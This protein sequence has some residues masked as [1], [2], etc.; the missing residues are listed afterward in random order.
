[1][2]KYHLI[3]I[4]GAGMSSLACFLADYGHIVQG[5]DVLE[6]F[7]TQKNLEL[8]EIKILPFSK[9]NLNKEFI[10]I[11]GN[12]FIENEEHL[13]AK[14][15]GC[16]TYSYYEFLGLLSQKFYSIAIAG[17][18]GKTTTTN[19]IRQLLS[20]PKEVN[21]LIGDGLG[22]GNNQS[23]LFVFEACEYKR[24]FLHY[25][26]N[27]AVLTNIDF[28]H[29]DY[30]RDILDVEDAFKEFIKQS[31]IIVY[32]GDDKL[33]SETIPPEK[34]RISFGLNKNNDYY[35]ENISNDNNNTSYDL[36]KNN[37]FLGKI[38]IPL[39][40]IH[41]VYNSL[42]AIS[43]SF[44]F[45]EDLNIIREKLLQ[46]NKSK[47][48]FEEHIIDN[49]IIISDYAHHPNEIKA[50]IEATT[51]KYPF[52]KIIIYFQPH[53]YTRTISFLKDFAMALSLSDKV[54]LREIFSSAREIDK[55]ISIYD[56]AKLI[57]KCEVINDNS[58]IEIFKKHPNCVIIFMG[59]GDIDKYCNLY[60]DNLKKNDYFS[61]SS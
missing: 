58:Y 29:P 3:G 43:I 54:Y 61:V 14:K 24:H 6:P 2:L 46:Y 20:Y 12:A 31:E 40:G 19:I 49:Q 41:S 7:F 55:T 16:E 34:Q 37:R 4:K 28:D 48:R 50:T 27:I 42:A 25:Y 53:T 36:Y 44:I 15:I 26:P 47:R 52:K 17:S 39:F 60:L 38:K 21:Y 8:R 11:V 22:G 56:L 33:L 23:D 10:V 9:E 51:V 32:N 59:A 18:H 30:Y 5:S 57:D 13:E 1:M 45:C 35:A